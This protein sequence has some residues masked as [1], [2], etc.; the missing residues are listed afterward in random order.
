MAQGAKS[1]PWNSSEHNENTSFKPSPHYTL[2]SKFTYTK[3]LHTI[4]GCV[5][6]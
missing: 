4:C 1:E 2:H 6:F 3:L 5:Y